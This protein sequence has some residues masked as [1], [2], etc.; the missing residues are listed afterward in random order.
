MKTISMG[1]S[2]GKIVAGGGTPWPDLLGLDNR[3]VSGSTA[4]E[5][6]NNKENWLVEAQMAGADTVIVSLMGNDAR[7]ALEDG[8]VTPDEISTALRSMRA[9]VKAMLPA[10]VIVLLYA[11][12]Y[13]GRQQLSRI[14]IP[15][16]NSAIECA[17][18]GL[19]VEFLHT[20]YH[21]GDTAWD[22]KDI[23]PTQAG[24]EAIAFVVGN[25][26]KGDEAGA[27]PIKESTPQ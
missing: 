12:P 20:Q 19:P 17:C 6:A 23:H 10:R 5:W 1:D 27:Q 25:M 16:L 8:V 7:H 26:L 2:W 18:W 24:H 3:N 4:Q 11:D 22:G 13:E 15:L 14:A 9:V 21:L